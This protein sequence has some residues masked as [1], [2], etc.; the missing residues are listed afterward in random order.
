MENKKEGKNWNPISRR[1]RDDSADS[2]QVVE[3]LLI[4]GRV[5]DKLFDAEF[6]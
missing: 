6:D 5:Y 4:A 2:A 1:R 3:K